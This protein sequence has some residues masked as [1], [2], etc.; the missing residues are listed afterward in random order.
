MLRYSTKDRIR[1]AV[2][3]LPGATRLYGL[4]K[5]LLRPTYRRD[6]LWTVHNADFLRDPTFQRSYQAGLRRQPGTEMEWRSHVAIWA[7]S[8]AS[9]LPEGHFV[10]CGVNRGFLSST[11]IE[12]LDFGRMSERR[13]FLFDTF[14]GL[15]PELLTESDRAASWNEYVDVYDDVVRAFASFDNV[16]IVRGPVPTTLSSVDIESVAYLSIDMNCVQPEIEAIRYFW[17]RMV[18]GGIVLLDDYGWAGHEAQKLAADEFAKSEGTT[19]L[20]LPTGQG[21]LIKN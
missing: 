9:R 2:K 14:D 15:V 20:S 8:H 11:V 21:L 18:P 10:E 7:G 5:L 16:E 4:L 13:F 6:G 19:I 3:R 17:P 1:H 12:A